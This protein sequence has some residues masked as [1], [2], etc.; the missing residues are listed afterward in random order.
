MCSRFNTVATGWRIYTLFE[1]VN[2]FVVDVDICFCQLKVHRNVHASFYPN[3]AVVRSLKTWSEAECMKSYILQWE[4]YFF[5]A[6]RLC[7]CMALLCW[8]TQAGPRSGSNECDFVQCKYFYTLPNA[9]IACKNVSETYQKSN[10]LL[11]GKFL[12]WKYCLVYCTATV[13]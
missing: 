5:V 11:L 7:K 9:R 13:V 4:S 3:V 6:Q 12:A 8:S 2:V 10:E 1:F